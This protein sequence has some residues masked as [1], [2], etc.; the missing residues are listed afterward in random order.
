MPTEAA[1]ARLLTP[2]VKYWVCKSAP[3][4]HLRGDGVPR[5]QRL[6][7]GERRWRGS[8]ARRR[9]TRS[10]RAPATSC[11]ST[12]C[13]PSSARA[14]PRARRSPN[15]RARRGDLPGAAEAAK[16]IEQALSGRRE[17][18]QGPRCRR[19]ACAAGG[20]G[21][22]ARRGAVARWR[23]LSRARGCQGGAAR[24]TAPAIS[25]QPRPTSLL[26]RVLP[27]LLNLRIAAAIA[28]HFAAHAIVFRRRGTGS[29]RFS[30]TSRLKAALLCDPAA[31]ARGRG[32][33]QFR[34]ANEHEEIENEIAW[35]NCDGARLG[36]RDG[37]RL[38]DSV[39]GA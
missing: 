20:G 29:A 16:L 39:R 33:V 22:A 9:S 1:R 38:N 7:R 3:A 19:T 11:A 34:P 36:R 5:R 17:R 8:I 28:P 10:G 24:L 23:R 12:C 26:A 2:A 14:R 13:A 27:E 21:G 31:M 25:P 30:G 35:K 6:R 37:A 18:G 15:W 4:L 32:S